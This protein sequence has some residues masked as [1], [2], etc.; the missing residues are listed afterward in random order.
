MK[1]YIICPARPLSANEQAII[2]THTDQLIFEGWKVYNPRTASPEPNLA[3]RAKAMR[4]ADWVFVF[5]DASHESHFD[6]GMAFALEKKM[7]PLHIFD[8]ARI[9][10][11]FSTGMR[12]L[13]HFAALA[14]KTR[15]ASSPAT[16]RAKKPEASIQPP[17]AY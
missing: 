10:D 7:E 17:A 5:W 15:G 8:E 3:D 16:P 12:V 2:D 14:D 13:E 4:E 6:L 9:T 11:R 1:A